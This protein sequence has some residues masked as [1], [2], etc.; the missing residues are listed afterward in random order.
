MSWQGKIVKTVE[1]AGTT[2]IGTVEVEDG[3]SRMA[4]EVANGGTGALDA[5]SVEVQA[6]PDGVFKEYVNAAADFTAGTYKF[7]VVGSS[8]SPVTLANAASVVFVL[9][10]KGM[11][12]VKFVG[13]GNGTTSAISLYWHSR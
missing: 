11:H 8:G 10:V 1:V 5:F 3:A 2:E 13:S 4:V 6:H 7:P 9:D 12:A